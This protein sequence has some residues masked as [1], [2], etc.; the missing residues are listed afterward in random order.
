MSNTP[1]AYGAKLL[2]IRWRNLSDK[3]KER[4]NNTCLLCGDQTQPL[5][6][7]HD[8]YRGVD[9][10]DTPEALL[11]TVYCHCHEVLHTFPKE[12]LK[13]KKEYINNGRYKIF[14]FTHRGVRLMMFDIGELKNYYSLSYPQIEM[15]Y[16]NKL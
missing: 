1:S 16:N 2:D 5:Q 4:D 7:H 13:I 12:V 3:I 9:P 14:A 10:W 15:L 11:R 8:E 6:V